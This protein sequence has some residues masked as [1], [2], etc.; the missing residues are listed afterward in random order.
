MKTNNNDFIPEAVKLCFPNS[1]EFLKGST[2]KLL[3]KSNVVFMD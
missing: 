2:Y 3:N 1:L